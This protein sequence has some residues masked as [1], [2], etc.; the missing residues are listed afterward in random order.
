L[1]ASPRIQSDPRIAC[2][3]YWQVMFASGIPLQTV[4]V[5]VELRGDLKQVRN[6]GLTQLKRFAFRRS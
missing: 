4:S 2:R 5:L 1:E 6:L 3:F